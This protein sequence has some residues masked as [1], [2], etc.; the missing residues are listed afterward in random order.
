M[1]QE[2]FARKCDKCNKGMNAGYVLV[3]CEYYCSDECL[4]KEV[5]EQE[6]KELYE[7]DNAY[8][9]EWTEE[10]IDQDDEPIYENNIPSIIKID[11]CYT[12]NEDGSIIFDE[13]QMKEIFE[14]KLNNL[15][16]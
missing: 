10:D 9:T 4:H 2:Q 5:T 12:I 15:K 6:Y 14:T 16:N 3:D 1:K 8:Y 13:E 7:N 11:V